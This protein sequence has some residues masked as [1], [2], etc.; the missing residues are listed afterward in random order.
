MDA[1]LRAALWTLRQR[2]YAALAV[3]MLVV[4]LVCI[5]MGSFEIHRYAE[6]RHE[7]NVFKANA[8][9]APV[10]LTPALVPLVGQGPAPDAAAIRYRTVTVSGSYLPQAEQY[11]DDQTQGGHQGFYVLTPLRTSTGVLLVARGFVAATAAETRPAD[12]PAPPAG[13]VRLTGRLQTTQTGS[14]QLGRLGHG[15]ITSINARQ[16]AARLAAPTY[17]AYLQLSADQPGASG[18][19]AIPEP[20]LSNP[21]G[22]APQWQLFSYVIQWYV[23]ALLALLVPF[24][25]SRA[26]VRDARRRFLG[27]D[28]DA[29]E[30]GLE[31]AS[32][33]QPALEA[34]AAAEGALVPRDAGTVARLDETAQQRWDRAVRLADRYGRSLGPDA[35]P[36]LAARGSGPPRAPAGPPAPAAPPARVIRDSGAMPHRS[37]DAYH[38]SYNDYL[39]ELALADGA[40]PEVQLPDPSGDE[41]RTP[42]VLDDLRPR[43]I[44]QSHP[45]PEDVEQ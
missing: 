10:A 26:E 35:G 34:G 11:V 8:H 1:V 12:V 22:G 9:A 5:G 40:V 39:W 23:F 19:T 44:E 37:V 29:T 27:I 13:L 21:A 38:G 36:E 2:R 31:P 17:Q 41:A 18:L 28:P 20:D 33:Q 42:R 25:V 15:E 4:A 45:A 6:K 30:F 32:P 7:N 24:L 3:G 14:D 16:Q 43:P